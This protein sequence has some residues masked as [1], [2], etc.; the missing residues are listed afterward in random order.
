[1]VVQ[2]QPKQKSLLGPISSGKKKNGYDD[3]FLSSQLWQEDYNRVI[4]DQA[5]LDPISYFG[6]P[7]S[8]ITRAK[9][10]GGMAQA[11]SPEFKPHYS[12]QNQ[13]GG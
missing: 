3:M 5:S 12:H 6:D 13:K 1:V 8:K 11:E 9:T 4:M 2:G 7:I 10:A